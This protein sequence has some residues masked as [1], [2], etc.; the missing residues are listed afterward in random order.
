MRFIKKTGDINEWYSMFKEMKECNDDNTEHYTNQSDEYTKKEI[1]WY[2]NG[3]LCVSHTTVRF[4]KVNYESCLAMMIGRTLAN[5]DIN[6]R[7]F[8]RNP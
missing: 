5:L 1:V 4:Y 7:E 6:V 8:I 2:A 3:L